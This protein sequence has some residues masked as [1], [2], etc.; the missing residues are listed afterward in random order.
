MAADIAAAML[1]R[2]DEIREDGE[3]IGLFEFLL[4]SH[5]RRRSVKLLFGSNLVDLA[6][7]VGF[8]IPDI[9][10]ED[11]MYVCGVRMSADGRWLSAAGAAV[12][13]NHYV[14]AVPLDAPDEAAQGKQAVAMARL[15]GFSLKATEAC[16]NCGIDC[17]TA[18][19]MTLRSMENFTTLRSELADSLESKT[20]DA[21]WQAA[22]SRCG[23]MPGR[24]HGDVV[25][26][27]AYSST[28]V[29]VGGMGPPT[30]ASSAASATALADTAVAA[31]PAAALAAEP[32]ENPCP[33][34]PPLPPLG[35]MPSPALEAEPH[36]AA[37][38]AAPPTALVADPT[39]EPVSLVPKPPLPPPADKPPT[40]IDYLRSKPQD[41]SFRLIKDYNTFMRAQNEWEEK[42]HK[43]QGRPVPQNTG[44]KRKNSTSSLKH[45]MVTA[46]AY[47]TWREGP[48]A[49]S[50]DHLKA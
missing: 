50:R 49:T 41:E 5:L 46:S 22:F 11:P 19:D 28:A 29:G 12:R 20:G 31:A 8:P 17:M 9:F 1:I 32:S 45:R 30:K 24:D 27:S 14:I 7:V 36:A 13:I 33:P 23:E 38:G 43:P 26:A 44:V 18:A 39:V 10:L 6:E 15:A 42:N 3:Y 47:R 35:D 48:G 21:D 16:G 25:P 2:A 4:W 40:F 34:L 37:L